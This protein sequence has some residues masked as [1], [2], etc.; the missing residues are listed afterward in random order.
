MFNLLALWLLALF[1][2][3]AVERSL[4]A[5]SHANHPV[6]LE[7]NELHLH[8]Y[9]HQCFLCDLHVPA[10]L[11]YAILQSDVN[12]PYHLVCFIP[13]TKAEKVLEATTSIYVRGPPAQ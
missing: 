8:S 13:K 2:F 3:P 9:E 7:Q 6:C 4:H 5:F 1:L 12:I 10:D 11:H